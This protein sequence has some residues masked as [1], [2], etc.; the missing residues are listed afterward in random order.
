[1]TITLYPY[2][3]EPLELTWKHY[4]LTD[5]ISHVN[6]SNKFKERAAVK[7]IIPSENN[8]PVSGIKDKYLTKDRYNV[9]IVNWNAQAYKTCFDDNGVELSD[10]IDHLIPLTNPSNIHMIGIGIGAHLAGYAASYTHT[11]H[12]YKI[13]RIYALQRYFINHWGKYVHPQRFGYPET[14]K[15]ALMR[16]DAAYV[17]DI[18]YT[19]EII[20]YQLRGFYFEIPS[21]ANA[22]FY[23]F[24]LDRGLCRNNET[25]KQNLAIKIFI[26]TIYEKSNS[27]YQ[28]AGNTFEAIECGRISN[29]GERFCDFN[30]QG[31]LYNSVG[32][33]CS[34]ILFGETE[35]R[36]FD[37]GCGTDDFYYLTVD[38]NDVSNKLKATEQNQTLSIRI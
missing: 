15:H 4:V 14:F 26:E 23:F 34:N 33:W 11:R 35:R 10:F 18:T 28:K 17:E 36:S 1:M 32:N 3:A 27:G 30:E 29:R 6:F 5:N 22:T 2:E 9:F 25:C 8:V 24:T 12:G 7:I 37:M 21:K 16:K 13:G 19:E 20:N 38:E 31:V